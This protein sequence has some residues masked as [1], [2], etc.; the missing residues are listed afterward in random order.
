LVGTVGENPQD[1]KE[2]GAPLNLVNNHQ[3]LQRTQGR[4][5]LVETGQAGGVFK[6]KIIGG[7]GIEKLAGKGG[8]AAL[9]RARQGDD[10]ATVQ[11]RFDRVEDTWSFD[12]LGIVP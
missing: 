12:H 1:G 7:I 11:G 6:V 5:G 4:H 3:A 2:F 8:F 10:P 9:A